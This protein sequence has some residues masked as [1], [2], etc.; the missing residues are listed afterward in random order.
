MFDKSQ[1]EKL[2][3]QARS[4]VEWLPIPNGIEHATAR[5]VSAD[6]SIIIGNGWSLRSAQ[7]IKLETNVAFGVQLLRWQEDQVEVLE[8]WHEDH[9]SKVMGISDDAKVLVGYGWPEGEYLRRRFRAFRWKDGVYES[10]AQSNR[11]ASSSQALA[12]SADGR[13]VVGTLIENG[14]PTAFTWDVANGLRRLAD[15]FKQAGGDLKS[16]KLE[17]ALSLS[18][19]GT[20]I[21][22]YARRP[23]GIQKCYIMRLP[24]ELMDPLRGQLARNE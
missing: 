6:E 12:V 21:A 11:A 10:I 1:N 20:A 2:E 19:D 24:I 18:A 14:V 15:V 7:K 4:K 9:A 13:I 17:S 16:W 22:G 23:D 8:K 3:I 5:F